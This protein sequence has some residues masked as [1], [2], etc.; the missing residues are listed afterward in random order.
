M[1][2]RMQAIRHG[3]LVM[4]FPPPTKPPAQGYDRDPELIVRAGEPGLAEFWSGRP[5]GVRSRPLAD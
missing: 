2:D 5:G 1:N 3:M 4:P